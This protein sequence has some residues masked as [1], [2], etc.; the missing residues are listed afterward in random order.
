MGALALVGSLVNSGASVFVV[1]A[2]A[3]AGRLHPVRRA[4]K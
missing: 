4:V 3:A 2:A 1:Y